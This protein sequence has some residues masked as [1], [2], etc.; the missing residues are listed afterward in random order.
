[1]LVCGVLGFMFFFFKQKTA[2]E[3]RISD[4]S[5]DVCSSDLHAIERRLSGNVTFP[6]LGDKFSVSAS[7]SWSKSDPL[8]AGDRPFVQSRA[9]YILG[10]NPTYFQTPFATNSFIASTDRKSVE[11]G[12]GVA[13]SV[14]IGG[15]LIIKKKKKKKKTK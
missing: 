10:N 6:L 4:W 13:V 11:M 14:A 2:Y 15:R 1:M 12:K 8:L 5:S 7:A 9:D 3:M